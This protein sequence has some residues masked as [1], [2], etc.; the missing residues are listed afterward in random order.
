MDGFHLADIELERRGLL[1]RKGAPETFDAFGYARLL[2]TLRARPNHTVFAPD[3]ERGLE[4][5]LAAA[6]SIEPSDD[7]I[8]AEGNYLML[9]GKA[10]SAVRRQLDTAWHVVTDA[11]LRR[12]RLIAR[13]EAF[14]K[15]PDAAREWV[16]IVDEPNARLIES[17]EGAADRILDLRHWMPPVDVE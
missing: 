11:A 14:G 16:R 3:F 15:A 5:P 6:R 7:I 1:D 10:W 13:H 8:V 17:R 2:E 4:Q 9:S 12:H